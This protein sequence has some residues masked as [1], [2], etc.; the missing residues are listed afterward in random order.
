M[1]DVGVEKD[2][3]AEVKDGTVFSVAVVDSLAGKNG[4]VDAFKGARLPPCNDLS[5]S[6]LLSK[7]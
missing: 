3:G 6:L 7:S 2:C 5:K 1:D 4:G